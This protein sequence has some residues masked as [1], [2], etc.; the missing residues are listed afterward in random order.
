MPTM[1]NRGKELL[2]ISPKDPKKLEYSTNQGR[3]WNPRYAGNS[4]VG[5]FMD[6]MDN[7]NEILGTTSKGLFYSKNDGRVWNPRR[8]Y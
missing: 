4:G 1:I 5:E 6:L 2:R 8:R 7:G 3:V